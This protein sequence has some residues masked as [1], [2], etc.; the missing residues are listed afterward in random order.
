M[1]KQIMSKRGRRFDEGGEVQ[2]MP[3]ARTAA[4]DRE[5]EDK[6]AGLEASNKEKSTGFFERLRM[7][8]IDDPNSEAYKRF[9]AGRGRADRAA[10]VPVEDKSFTDVPPKNAVKPAEK[11]APDRTKTYESGLPSNLSGSAFVHSNPD[12]RQSATE[13]M[14]YPD[15]L[16]R[17]NQGQKFDL[18]V[19]SDAG[20]SLGRLSP[21]TEKKK[22]TSK[23]AAKKVVPQAALEKE[24]KATV[25]DIPKSTPSGQIPG[26]SP[27]GWTGG[28][29]EKI[30]SSEL[31]RNVNNALNAVVPG[32][33]RGFSAA[34]NAAQGASKTRALAT[35]E[36]PV[37]FLGKSGAKQVGGGPELSSTA[38][39]AL[40]DNPTRQLAAP[41]KQIDETKKLA[42]PPK[43]ITGPTKSDLV[44]RDRTARAIKRQT[45]MGEENASR[46]G[47]DTKSSD[48]AE[49]AKKI[50]DK[51]GGDDFSL[52]MKRGGK[53]KNFGMASGGSVASSRGD[54]IAQRGKT[55]GKM[56]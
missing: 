12:F 10:N 37:T 50:R 23:P 16:G 31:G 19:P 55:R 43:Q 6:A 21:Y 45:E 26:S 2:N 34:K 17:L 49:K 8:N 28:K 30:N 53:V 47:L 29:G 44:N 27:E 42:A 54:G 33:A 52:G 32:P 24:R 5:A 38:R 11:P 36:T 3:R 22:T 18:S 13:E 41:S 4:E 1:K 39:K 35:T 9:G 40:Q 48:Y 51:L 14:L 20:S 46:Y 15:K 56:C 7:G 25:N